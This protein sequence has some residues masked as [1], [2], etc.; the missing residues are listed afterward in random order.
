M[1]ILERYRKCFDIYLWMSNGPV[2]RASQYDN[3]QR[4]G[5]DLLFIVQSVLV[6]A[7][8]QYQRCHH[9]SLGTTTCGCET[10]ELELAFRNVREH[11]DILLLSFFYGL[12][13]LE[14]VLEWWI[15][16]AHRRQ[17]S[18]F[19]MLRNRTLLHRLQS[20][21]TRFQGFERR[22]VED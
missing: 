3:R 15:S 19:G 17:Y 11:F 1:G 4:I 16:L 9:R 13:R 8:I 10:V 12:H 2:G 18:P 21:K 22:V 6:Q 14:V 7:S 5:T 20:F